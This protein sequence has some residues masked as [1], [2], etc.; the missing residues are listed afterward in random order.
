MPGEALSRGVST[1]IGSRADP[2]AAVYTRGVGSTGLE[3]EAAGDRASTEPLL[4]WEPGDSIAETDDKSGIA[5]TPTD[6]D[7]DPR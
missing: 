2:A 6:A 4:P 5:R 7:G 3:G 1:A